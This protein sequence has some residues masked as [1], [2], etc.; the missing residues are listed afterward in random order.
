MSS[1]SLINL[2]QEQ[3]DLTSN[4]QKTLVLHKLTTED[5]NL[6]EITEKIN[7]NLFRATN[8]FSPDNPVIIGKRIKIEEMKSIYSPVKTETKKKIKIGIRKTITSINTSLR[9]DIN[10]PTNNQLIKI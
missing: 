9:S 8:Y 7:K 6:E 10:K 2:E 5:E 3:N 1:D 4:N